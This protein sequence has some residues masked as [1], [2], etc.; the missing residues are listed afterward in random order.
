[1]GRARL[2]KKFGSQTKVLGEKYVVR[3]IFAKV[4][5]KTPTELLYLVDFL[6]KHTDLAKEPFWQ[7]LDLEQ[8]KRVANAMEYV[9]V[10]RGHVQQ[11]PLAVQ[12]RYPSKYILLSGQGK[13]QLNERAGRKKIDDLAKAKQKEQSRVKTQKERI[14][15][16]E[17]KKAGEAKEKAE[18]KAGLTKGKKK[19]K[20]H[21]S[22]LKNIYQ[23]E[24]QS[25]GSGKKNPSS[26]MGNLVANLMLKNAREQGVK[27]TGV[28]GSIMDKP[29]TYVVG[30]AS[31]AQRE[32]MLNGTARPRKLTK[33]DLGDSPTSELL[34]T[35]RVF[36]RVKYPA[37]RVLDML[38][39]EMKDAMKELKEIHSQRSK[40]QTTTVNANLLEVGTARKR[41]EKNKSKQSGELK[42]QESSRV[43][44]RRSRKPPSL[45]DLT[46]D[47]K[48]RHE[49]QRVE[50]LAEKLQLAKSGVEGAKSGVEGDYMQTVKGVLPDN[51]RRG[52]EGALRFAVES[53]P[54]EEAEEEARGE[55][56]VSAAA[57]WKKAVKK[58]VATQ[59]M[60]SSVIAE[61]RIT[62]SKIEL[63]KRIKMH[64]RQLDEHE[65][66]TQPYAKV[67]M[68]SGAEYLKLP[69]RAVEN[70]FKGNDG[71][72]I[73]EWEKMLRVMGL[74]FLI[75]RVRIVDMGPGQTFVHENDNSRPNSLVY[76]LEEGTSLMYSDAHLGSSSTDATQTGAAK[77]AEAI[78]VNQEGDDS[79]SNHEEGERKGRGGRRASALDIQLK[80]LLEKQQQEEE[81]AKPGYQRVIAASLITA[82]HKVSRENLSRRVAVL[83]RQGM[84][85]EVSALLGVPQPAS[86]RTVSKCRFLV[87][88]TSTLLR[89]LSAWSRRELRKG[90]MAAAAAKLEMVCETKGVPY[91]LEQTIEKTQE[92]EGREIEQENKELLMRVKVHDP[93]S[94]THAVA[95]APPGPAAYKE[96]RKLVS[97]KTETG[98]SAGGG[99]KGGSAGDDAIHWRP[100]KQRPCTVKQK[101]KTGVYTEQAGLVYTLRQTKRS[102]LL[103][104][105]QKLAEN[106]SRP[107][108]SKP[109]TRG[110]AEAPLWKQP[111]AR[112]EEE[113]QV[114][115]ELCRKEET[116]MARLL[117]KKRDEAQA[118]QMAP[119]KA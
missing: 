81:V 12:K 86:V 3:R 6:E 110:Q 99:R 50:S 15:E 45:R 83:G 74:S 72:G 93:T 70:I 97:V 68:Q 55:Q 119:T 35:G 112:A 85:G 101:A 114:T 48:V 10:A 76:I 14:A 75:K 51:L 92:E 24:T 28:L 39:E 37:S 89:D 47:A 69:T 118:H 62:A 41:S 111:E 31:K 2:A 52:S 105:L 36:G 88:E 53:V 95:S 79:S 116:A 30:A 54:L 8:K 117:V 19:A 20:R 67:W 16:Y 25:D 60:A 33:E 43:R 61:R 11:I 100:T 13:A 29:A 1:M 108:D 23:R 22:L 87:V 4:E 44:R 59:R 71:D 104:Q 84:V 27:R 32:S 58:V 56:K 78:G 66:L 91:P 82:E 9:S 42:R 103:R 49:G 102:A 46:R 38:E 80:H 64:R 18:A 73:P 107:V 5:P 40:T 65:D 109:K 7:A 96:R 34:G 113:R 98:E 90:L 77:E 63:A 21:W 17:A 115:K 106:Q 94:I 57:K 26:D